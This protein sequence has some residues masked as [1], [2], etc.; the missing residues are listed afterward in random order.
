MTAIAAPQQAGIFQKDIYPDVGF[1]PPN[2]TLRKKESLDVVP[3][4]TLHLDFSIM[5]MLSWMPG[6][7]VLAR[8]SSK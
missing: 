4:A 7:F 8:N 1:L 5:Q 6:F 3:S 2:T